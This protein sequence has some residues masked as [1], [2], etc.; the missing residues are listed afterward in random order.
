M[1][2]RDSTYAIP[3]D[4]APYVKVSIE[5]VLHTLAEAMVLVFL[6]MYLFLQNVRYTLIPALVVPVAMLGS[7]AV[8]LDVYKRQALWTRSGCVDG[9]GHRGPARGPA[10]WRST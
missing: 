1:C 4:T 9:C 3:Y 8:M 5:Q 10:S 6:V 7:F 2:I